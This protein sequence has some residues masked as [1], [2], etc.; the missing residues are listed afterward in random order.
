MHSHITS[1]AQVF[2]AHFD[3]MLKLWNCLNYHLRQYNNYV[4]LTQEVCAILYGF[5]QIRG[6]CAGRAGVPKYFPWNSRCHRADTAALPSGIAMLILGNFHFFIVLWIFNC[7]ILQ[8]H[9]GN[10][11]GG[12]RL[13]RD[14][15]IRRTKCVD[16]RYWD[17]QWR[18]LSS[19][20][21]P[22]ES[23]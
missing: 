22:L 8:L 14:R 19:V 12:A 23:L 1:D 15:P 16:F 2:V 17:G 4:F 13:G 11:K 3:W 9:F 7:S 10:I 20:Q 5:L 6:P 18:W 21:R